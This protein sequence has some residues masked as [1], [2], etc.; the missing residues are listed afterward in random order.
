MTQTTIKREILH[1]RSLICLSSKK[2]SSYSSNKDI[3]ASSDETFQ[4]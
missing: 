4:I 1:S 3:T 2:L